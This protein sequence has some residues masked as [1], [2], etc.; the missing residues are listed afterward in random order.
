MCTALHYANASSQLFL[1]KICRFYL[2]QTGS[3]K[4]RESKE[5]FKSHLL[6]IVVAISEFS[7]IIFETCSYRRKNR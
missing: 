6:V 7:R 5:L 1:I 3:R 4:P 2:L